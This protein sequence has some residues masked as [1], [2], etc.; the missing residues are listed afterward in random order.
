MYWSVQEIIINA[1]KHANAKSIHISAVSEDRYFTI[2]VLYKATNQV[3]R[4]LKYK[5]LRVANYGTL[6]IKD[7]LSIIGAKQEI[8]IVDGYATHIIK[9]N[10]ENTGT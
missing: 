9:T 8:S 4:W 2:S 1:F 5:N 6:I 7:R 10:Y 3:K